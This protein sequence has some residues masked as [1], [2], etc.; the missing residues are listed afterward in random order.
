MVTIYELL[1]VDEDASK[2]EIEKSYSRLV[3]E[4]SQNPKFDEKTNKENEMILNKM[5]IAYEILTNDAKR[6][7]YDEDLAKKR[8][9]S[10]IASLETTKK[11]EEESNP[12]KSEKEINQNLGNNAVS[13]KNREDL[14]EDEDTIHYINSQAVESITSRQAGTQRP[15]NVPKTKN[16]TRESQRD[17]S[18]NLSKQEKENIRNAAKQE[19]DAKL[20]KVQEAENEYKNAYNKAYK[21]YIRQTKNA[22][23]KE[24]FRKIKIILI[25]ILVVFLTGIIMWSIPPVRKLLIE[26]YETNFLIKFFVDIVKIILDS[27]FGIFKK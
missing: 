20:K 26:L 21:E 7:K 1:E 18:S 27:I 3:L 13:F 11:D 14:K 25:T 2:E 22:A 10:L 8:A 23:I 6:K 12:K 16:V 17:T 9:E 4:F 5:K 24:K 19:F 15:F